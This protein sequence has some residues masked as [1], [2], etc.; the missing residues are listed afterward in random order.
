M[1]EKIETVGRLRAWRSGVP[2]GAA[3]GLVPTMGALHAGHAALIEAARR[4][5]GVVVLSIFVNPLQFNSEDD[6]A[7]YP[8]TPD[9][10]VAF[11]H[12]RGIDVVFMPAT[13]DVY[14]GAAR[15]QR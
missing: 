12:E 10:D 3:V 2:D 1:L 6:L 7:R 15:V 8:R 5:C 14:P 13:V 11:C 9:A 4:E